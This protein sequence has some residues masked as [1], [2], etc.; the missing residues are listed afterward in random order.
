VLTAGIALSHL[1]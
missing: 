1:G